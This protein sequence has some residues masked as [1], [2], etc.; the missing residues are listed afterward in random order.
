MAYRGGEVVDV[1]L[2]RG[3]CVRQTQVERAGH[4]LD[5]VRRVELLGQLQKLVSSRTPRR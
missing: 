1:L 2:E 4:V 3:D 5:V